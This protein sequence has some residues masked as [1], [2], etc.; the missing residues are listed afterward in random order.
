M[1]VK[2]LVTFGNE[3]VVKEQCMESHLKI[4]CGRI[5]ENGNSFTDQQD[6]KEDMNICRHY[7]KLFLYL[8]MAD[9]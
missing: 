9:S 2:H 8:L 1:Q 3:E 5:T 6:A 4:Y 7:E